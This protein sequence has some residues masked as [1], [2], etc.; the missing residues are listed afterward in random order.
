MIPN[1]PHCDEPLKLT[2]AQKVKV[3]EALA[4]L[5]NGKYLK[6]GCPNCRAQMKLQGDGSLFDD[7]GVTPGQAPAP[8][9]SSKLPVPPKPPDVSWLAAGEFTEREVIED[10]PMAM[11]LMEPGEGQKEAVESFEGMGYQ[12]LLAESGSDAIERMRFV[13]FS[14]V[15]LSDG[16]EKGGISESVFHAHMA[17]LPMTK[18]RFMYYILVS[19]KFHTFY[20]LEALAFSANLVVNI[21][22]VPHMNVI[23]RKGLNDYEDLFSP[24]LETLEAHGKI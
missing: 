4:S 14:A 6:L 9:T 2:E 1:C 23:L 16:F 7:S 12:T 8:Q 15:V 11:I 17:N 10:I 21:S 22:D 18:R 3:D 13:N 24:F 20:D 19:E 5:S